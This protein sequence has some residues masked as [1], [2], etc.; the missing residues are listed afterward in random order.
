MATT[1]H[2][3]QV[4]NGSGDSNDELEMQNIQITPED[5]ESPSL[6]P[7][8]GA[9]DAVDGGMYIYRIYMIHILNQ[10]KNNVHKS[11]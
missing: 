1:A 3:E 10:K 5:M 4:D 9:H 7:Q 8:M 11:M 6:G 2:H